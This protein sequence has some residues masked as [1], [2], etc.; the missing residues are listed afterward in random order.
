MN[1]FDKTKSDMIMLV[2]LGAPAFAPGNRRLSGV[3][4][5]D[6]LVEFLADQM[7]DILAAEHKS[8]RIVDD[9]KPSE[10]DGAEGV[11][12]VVDHA[13]RGPNGSSPVLPR[14]P[15]PDNYSD[16]ALNEVLHGNEVLRDVPYVRRASPYVG[17]DIRRAAPYVG[18][19]TLSFR[20]ETEYAKHPANGGRF[21]SG[22]Y[23]SEQ[24]RP[25]SPFNFRDPVERRRVAEENSK[26]IADR[27][28]VDMN[29][30]SI[31][32]V[33]K[34]AATRGTRPQDKLPSPRLLGG[35]VG[36]DTPP[37]QHPGGMGHALYGSVL[38]LLRRLNI[39]HGTATTFADDFMIHWL[40]KVNGPLVASRV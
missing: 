1:R 27:P 28:A 14:Y 13:G 10:R 36:T 20:P 12:F 21:S 31:K 5:L 37:W 26:A 35:T 2:M 19:E 17:T 8:D 11:N 40:V 22:G 24:E 4:D 3:S 18:T 33:V 39:D 30:H 34:G 23:F 15:L 38:D 6:G 25:A 9:V 29:G 7:D 16:A 32:A